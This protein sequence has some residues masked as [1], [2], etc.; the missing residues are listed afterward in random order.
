MYAFFRTLGM[1]LGVAVGGNIFQNMMS[2]KLAQLS[3]PI[4]IA[5]HAESF[6]MLL[7]M[8]GEDDPTRHA[9]LQAYGHGFQ[10]VIMVMTAISASGLVSSLVI[11]KQSMDKSLETRHKTQR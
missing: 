4:Y 6:I 2:N 7:P 11:R 10:G 5:H 3:Q 9:I 1:T 8:L